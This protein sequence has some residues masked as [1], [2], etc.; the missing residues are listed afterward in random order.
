MENKPFI[1][2]TN[3]FAVLFHIVG[4]DQPVQIPY[5]ILEQKLFAVC[6]AEGIEP[7]LGDDEF[8]SYWKIFG[9]VISDVSGEESG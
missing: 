3:I 7:S 2:N 9:V 1:S 5:H 6:R 8:V 4:S